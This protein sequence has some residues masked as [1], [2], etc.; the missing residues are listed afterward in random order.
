VRTKYLC[1][2]P[3]FHGPVLRPFGRLAAAKQLGEPAPP[4][5]KPKCLES[6]WLR[7]DSA[8]HGRRL[9]CRCVTGTRVF[10]RSSKRKYRVTCLAMASV[11]RAD[12]CRRPE[13]PA[14]QSPIRRVDWPGPREGW[15][16]V[17]A[18]SSSLSCASPALTLRGGTTTRWSGVASRRDQP[19]LNAEW[20]G[21]C[22]DGTCRMTPSQP[23]VW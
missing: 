12:R 23:S 18:P 3:D 16:L 20:R 17:R 4:R 6:H 14:P 2:V 1:T 10:P 13:S 8:V 15:L 21:A 11:P 7:A 9:H 5:A 22:M 19:N